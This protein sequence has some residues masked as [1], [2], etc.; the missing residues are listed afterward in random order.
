MCDL[1]CVLQFLLVLFR[2]HVLN[3]NLLVVLILHLVVVKRLVVVL[4]V[5]V[6]VMV[7]VVVLQ[8]FVQ[9]VC[10]FVVCITETTPAGN[11]THNFIFFMYACNEATEYLRN[12]RYNR[13]MLAA[14]VKI[15]FACFA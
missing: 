11:F 7:Q 3:Q 13:S 6:V 9:N 2:K 4:L 15:V 1:I 12:K 5:I 10:I 14:S 8:M